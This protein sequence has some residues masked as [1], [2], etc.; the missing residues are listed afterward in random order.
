MNMCI[1]VLTL[2]SASVFSA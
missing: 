2:L 1:E